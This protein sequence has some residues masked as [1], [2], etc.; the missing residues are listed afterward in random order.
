M[1]PR[2]EHDWG[3]ES[4][5]SVGA[6][7]ISPVEWRIQQ[8][9]RMSV[10]VSYNSF[11]LKVRPVT[12]CTGQHASMVTFHYSVE[13]FAQTFRQ[14]F[15]IGKVC[16]CL[17]DFVWGWSPERLT[18]LM[19]LSERPIIAILHWEWDPTCWDIHRPRQTESGD[20]C[21]QS[22]QSRQFWLLTINH[23]FPS[24]ISKFCS[25]HE[26]WLSVVLINV[27]ESHHWR[28]VCGW[29]LVNHFKIFWIIISFRIKSQYKKRN[30]YEISSSDWSLWSTKSL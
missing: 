28:H 14:S 16:V 12:P 7:D 24:Q 2:H 1:K 10:S 22:L 3:R 4:R 5:A 8:M 9:R 21:D 30:I 17:L 18:G 11:H 6:G 26:H 13:S 23:S 20:G 25:W 19:R 29:D 27:W 15:I